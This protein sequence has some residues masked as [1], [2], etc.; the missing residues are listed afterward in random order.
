MP[1]TTTTTSRTTPWVKVN[2]CTIASTASPNAV[3]ATPSLIRLSPSKIVTMRGGAPSRLS[4]EVAATASVGATAAANARA[5][6]QPRCGST[7]VVTAPTAKM[8][9]VVAPTASAAI[10]TTFS[11]VSLGAERNAALYISGG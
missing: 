5:A 4:T 6:A 9:T 8:V 7:T 2:G 3:S 1:P 11:L 10:G